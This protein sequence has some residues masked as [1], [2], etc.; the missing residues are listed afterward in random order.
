MKQRSN[1]EY[2]YTDIGIGFD[3]AD[4]S[5]KKGARLM[6]IESRLKVLNGEI[7]LI[8]SPGKGFAAHIKIP[9]HGN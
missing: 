2:M 3:F 4:R 5:L 1:L 8:S 7:K 6:N 9:I